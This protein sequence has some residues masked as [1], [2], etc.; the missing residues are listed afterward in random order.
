MN[1]NMD[2][3]NHVQTVVVPRQERTF[4]G[5]YALIETHFP[6]D[7][8]YAIISVKCSDDEYTHEHDE[9]ADMEFLVQAETFAAEPTNTEIIEAL[10]GRNTARDAKPG[11]YGFSCMWNNA[12]CVC[13]VASTECPHQQA[14]MTAWHFPFLGVHPVP[15][16]E[17]HPLYGDCIVFVRHPAN[18]Q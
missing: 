5:L 9:C 6:C 10:W 18:V 17:I 4:S 7:T 12:T 1:I 15:G 14:Q 16:E 13:Y 8:P 3:S 11:T 2:T